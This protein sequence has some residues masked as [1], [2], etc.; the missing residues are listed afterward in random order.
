MSNTRWKFNGELH[1]EFQINS[2]V[3]TGNMDEMFLKAKAKCD[4]KWDL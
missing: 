3:S 2:S 1:N 4:K